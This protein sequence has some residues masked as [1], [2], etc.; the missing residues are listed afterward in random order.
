MGGESSAAQELA[1]AR[2]QRCQIKWY[3]GGGG[4]GCHWSLGGAVGLQESLHLGVGRALP[5]F[6]QGP[7]SPCLHP[8]LPGCLNEQ[9]ACE[10]PR[11]GGEGGPFWVAH[12]FCSARVAHPPGLRSPVAPAGTARRSFST[13]NRFRLRSWEASAPPA[14]GL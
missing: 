10:P 5:P 4:R 14:S 6:S 1:R 2:T 8:S 13:K 7:T 9:E 3:D 12:Q 11:V